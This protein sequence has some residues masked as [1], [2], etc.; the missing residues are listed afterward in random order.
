MD[1]CP[2]VKILA[3]LKEEVVKWQADGDHVMILA[4]MNDDVNT[5]AL[6]QFCQ[7]LNLVEAI[8][9]LHGP[10]QKPTHQRGRLAI[11]GIYIS[12]SLLE[13]SKGGFLP[14]GEVMGSDHRALWIDISAGHVGMDQQEIIASPASRRLKCQDPRIVAKYNQELMRIISENGWEGRISDL[15]DAA[16]DNTWTEQ[17]EKTYND[18][19]NEL[20]KAKIDAE[21]RCRKICAGKTPW[22]PALTQ[23]IQRIMY[24]K[25]TVKRATGGRIST[26]VL[27]RRAHK[28]QIIFSSEHWNWHRR[29]LNQRIVSAYD[30]YYLIKAQKDRQDTWLTQ[31][32]EA[33][34]QAKNVPKTRLW[35]QIKQTESARNHAQQVK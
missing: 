11:D 18:I 6:I 33:M 7:D 23:A 20:T 5:P 10:A 35:K 16:S 14:F 32:V 27:K 13:G 29:E 9:T 4:D 22:T 21:H 28:G 26:T 15:F 2:R 1:C 31:L 24:W 25:G 17:H 30:D 3:D 8:S 34:L 19:D 12:R